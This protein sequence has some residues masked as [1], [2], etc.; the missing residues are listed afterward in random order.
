MIDMRPLQK[1]HGNVITLKA[2]AAYVNSCG[3]DLNPEPNYALIALDHP[4]NELDVF[5]CL[6]DAIGI[7]ESQED[8]DTVSYG[9]KDVRSGIVLWSNNVEEE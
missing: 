3:Q 2:F 9:V 1:A 6:D 4:E 5:D 7:A 8:A